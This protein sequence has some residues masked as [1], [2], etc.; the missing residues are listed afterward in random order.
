MIV[1]TNN[2]L[3]TKTEIINLFSD[4][5]DLGSSPIFLDFQKFQM[6]I[7]ES[8][9]KS[10]ES[11]IWNTETFHNIQNLFLDFQKIALTKSYT[12][13]FIVITSNS[14][15]NQNKFQEIDPNS[16]SARIGIFVRRNSGIYLV[17][18]DIRLDLNS[19]CLATNAQN[20][21]SEEVTLLKALDSKIYNGI[22]N[23]VHYHELIQLFKD[24]K[25]NN[26]NLTVR[27]MFKDFFA[28]LE[29]NQVISIYAFK[30]F[31][32]KL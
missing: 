27:G 4:L 8:W 12:H 30:L 25:I 17:E 1:H 9:L 31:S 18:D 11:Q 19:P 20:S 7:C 29:G 28:S 14:E 21:L 3:D 26:P 10:Q 2:S 32:K 16:L 6:A 22:S 15:L 13:S 23:G 5:P 24:S